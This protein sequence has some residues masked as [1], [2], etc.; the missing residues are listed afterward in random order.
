VRRHSLQEQHC[1]LRHWREQLRL[2]SNQGS[3]ERI[4]RGTRAAGPLHGIPERRKRAVQILHVADATPLRALPVPMQNKQPGLQREQG[5]CQV[6]T[7]CVAPQDKALPADAPLGG[8]IQPVLSHI[9]P[10]R[11]A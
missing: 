11:P 8:R 7:C 1:A 3:V 9:L 4:P 2:G 5:S 6:A 10:L